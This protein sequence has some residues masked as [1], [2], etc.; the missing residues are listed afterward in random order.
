MSRFEQDVQGIAIEGRLDNAH[1]AIDEFDGGVRLRALHFD[2][3]VRQAIDQRIRGSA[4]DQVATVH[5]REFVAVDRL[6]K[7]VGGD[8]DR[9]SLP[10]QLIEAIPEG[11]PG[12]RRHVSRRFIEE[13][14]WWCVDRC[15]SEC[16]VLPR[17]DWHCTGER[18]YPFL[19]SSHGDYPIRRLDRFH[20]GQSVQSGVEPQVFPDGHVVVDP[21]LLRHVADDVLEV[22]RLPRQV[23]TQNPGGTFVLF[24]NPAQ[25]AD[26]RGLA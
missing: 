9:G 17:S 3:R 2:E 26:H 21:G 12:N 15:A 22:S 23:E 14:K 11:P 6:V 13:K 10:C 1:Q 5:Q 25:H 20:A 8:Q 16:Q 24:Q 4:C 7:V 18:V 19:K